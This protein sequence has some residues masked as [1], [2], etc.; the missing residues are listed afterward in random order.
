[1]HREGCPRSMQITKRGFRL[2]LSSIAV[3]KLRI[4]HAIGHA[5]EPNREGTG[6]NS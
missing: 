4:N 3:Q 5:S 1:M 2:R 6:L